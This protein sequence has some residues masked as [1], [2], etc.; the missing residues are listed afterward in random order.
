MKKAKLSLIAL[1]LASIIAMPSYALDL[2]GLKKDK[3]ASTEQ[4]VDASALQDGLVKKYV[5][6]NLEINTAQSLLAESL[7][8]KDS[9]AALQANAKALSA[10]NLDEKGLTRVSQSSEET[11]KLVAAAMAEG[12]PL[13]EESKKK[14][15]ES[16]PH[17]IGGM[18][19]TKDLPN[20]A[21]SFTSAAQ[22]QISSA[23]MMDK[24]KVKDKLATGVYVATDAPKFI[25]SSANTLKSI[26]AFAKT[27][28]IPVPKNATD[29]L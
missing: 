3:G 13:S 23:S 18:G 29:V 20:E 14:F 16:L 15:T 24:L 10:G 1:A 8:L 6:A 11:N 17:F 26:L 5:G 28:N 4:S 9:A 27:N 25:S 21:K 19:L 7:G 12:K 2:P 22:Q